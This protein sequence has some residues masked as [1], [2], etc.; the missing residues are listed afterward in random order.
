MKNFF[1]NITI[2][3]VLLL[4]VSATFAAQFTPSLTADNGTIVNVPSVRKALT[5]GAVNLGLPYS[6]AGTNRAYLTNATI[7]VYPGKDIRFELYAGTA[8]MGTDT[9]ASVTNG[10]FA[11]DYATSSDGTTFGDVKG[12][13]LLTPTSTVTNQRVSGVL[14]S[15]NIYPCKAVKFGILTNTTSRTL[16][17]TNGNVF[18]WMD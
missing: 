18:F 8:I 12:W 1:K 16:Y 5:T 7:A 14:Y 11:V 6:V 3:S 10:V 9:L 15:T 13:L 17:P 2:V 4:T